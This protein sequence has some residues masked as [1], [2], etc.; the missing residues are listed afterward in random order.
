MINNATLTG[1]LV[2][3][4]E[5]RYSQNGTQITTYTIAVNRSYEDNADFIKITC[6]GKSAEFAEKYFTKGMLV[7]VTGRIA[8]NSWQDDD[9]W[10]NDF[11]IVADSQHFLEPK[12]EDDSKNSKNS[13][14]NKNNKNSKI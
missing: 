10:H 11:S 12:K 9:V 5:T 6:F 4:P 14:N 13:K 1:R 3:E 7:G 2:R 8:T